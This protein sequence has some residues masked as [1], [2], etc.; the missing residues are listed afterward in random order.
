MS[1]WQKCD[2]DALASTSDLTLDIPSPD[3]LA[4]EA[5]PLSLPPPS[6]L[7][8]C[9]QSPLHHLR[10]W[11]RESGSR[12]NASCKARHQGQRRRWGAPIGTGQGH[13]HGEGFSVSPPSP[14]LR[15]PSFSHIPR[16]PHQW[17][18]AFLLLPQRPQVKERGAGLTEAE[19]RAL[20]DMHCTL[21]AGRTR[22]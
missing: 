10:R 18:H 5:H 2:E 22:A 17:I 20:S 14:L 12:G 9:P 19:D 16:H 1:L 6:P 3:F 21:G 8:L 11:S 4:L 15:V 13:C 7:S